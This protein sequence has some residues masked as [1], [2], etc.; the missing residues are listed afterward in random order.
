MN[1]EQAPLTVA[2]ALAQATTRL[3][4]SASAALDDQLLLGFS[5]NRPRSW[6]LAEGAAPIAPQALAEFE[7]HLAR[8]ARGEPL[9]YLM[10]A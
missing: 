7:A 5:M 1:P 9:A 2:V 4:P 3:R 8:R 10:A 6:L